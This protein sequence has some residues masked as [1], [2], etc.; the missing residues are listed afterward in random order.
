M[1]IDRNIRRPDLPGPQWQDNIKRGPAQGPR[2]QAEHVLGTNPYRQQAIE[3]GWDPKAARKRTGY[4][5]LWDDMGA[6]Q[7]DMSLSDFQ[8]QKYGASPWDLRQDAREA[9]RAD[10]QAARRSPTG[11]RPS[12]AG[13]TDFDTWAAVQQNPSYQARQ[14]EFA[15]PEQLAQ[16]SAPAIDPLDLRGS[17]QGAGLWN[18]AP[19]QPSAPLF[20]TSGGLLPQPGAAPQ[21]STFQPP[22]GPFNFGSYQPQFAEGGRDSTKKGR[23]WDGHVRG[24]EDG[25]PVMGN[26]GSGRRRKM[27]QNVRQFMRQNLRG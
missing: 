21:T 7:H 6:M 9:E 20:D 8:T 18:A 5:T 27:R 12:L 26:F 13:V 11:S 14:A 2:Q 3:G 10:M 25:R 24:P 19:E 1:D 17:L 23:S 16:S 22:T 4:N 15:G